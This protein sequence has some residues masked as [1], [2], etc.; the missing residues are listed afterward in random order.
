[1]FLAPVGVI[2]LALAR[3]VAPIPVDDPTLFLATF[4]DPTSV[5]REIDETMGAVLQDC[6]AAQD[7]I[8]VVS[9]SAR[10]SIEQVTFADALQPTVERSLGDILPQIVEPEIV[11]LDPRVL[12]DLTP[13]DRDDLLIEPDALVDTNVIEIAELPE[14][15]APRLTDPDLRLRPVD[16]GYGISLGSYLAAEPDPNIDVVEELSPVE[17]IEFEVALFGNPVDELDRGETGGCAEVSLEVLLDEVIPELEAMDAELAE[18]EEAIM[19]DP[20][21]GRAIEEWS[22]C[23]ATSGIAEAAD[24]GSLDEAVELTR[25]R[26]E[27]AGAD[28]GLLADAR[29]FERRLAVVDFECRSLTTDLAIAAVVADRGAPYVERSLE[30]IERIKEASR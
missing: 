21:F 7:Q 25:T 2:L 16:E 28:S 30:A 29:G 15:V 10:F 1:M 3:P 12:D 20:E 19:D 13:V 18:L 14:L 5:A 6:M 8:H 9:P 26:F 11:R 4:D 27:A 23:V 22:R 24:L 17:L